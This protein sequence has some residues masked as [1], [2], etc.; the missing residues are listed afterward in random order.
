MHSK[1]SLTVVTPHNMDYKLK[2]T[3]T[4]MSQT[5]PV[6]TDKNILG[7]T[8]DRGWTLRQHTQDSNARANTTECDEVPIS[9]VVWALKRVPDGLVQTVCTP[10]PVVC[11]FCMAAWLGS[12]SHAGV[13]ENAGLCIATGCTRS[14]P[15]AHLHAETKVLPLKDY[16]ELRGTQIFS[17][18]AAPEIHYTKGFTTQ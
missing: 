13:A 7:V 16:L 3:I 1:S 14:T 17:A 6:N 10:S 15:T 18:A 5:I 11:Q 9:Y 12:V 4:L 2:P 8:I